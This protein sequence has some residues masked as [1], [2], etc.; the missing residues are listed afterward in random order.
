MAL[1]RKE[2]RVESGRGR[3]SIHDSGTMLGRD[4]LAVA[5]GAVA[6][7]L[8]QAK[9]AHL[10]F[11][12]V[13]AAVELI[14]G[15]EHGSIAEVGRQCRIVPKAESSELARQVDL[16]MQETGQGPCLDAIWENQTVRVDD[17]AAE[18]RWPKFSRRAA[19]ADVRSMLSF[20]LYVAGGNLGALNVYSSRP[21]AFSDESE[22]VGLLV[23]THA[24]VA[25]AGVQRRDQLEDAVDTRDL[26]GRAIGIVMERYTI[27]GDRAFATLT[28]LSQQSN[29]KLRDIAAEIVRD[30]EAAGDQLRG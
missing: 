27:T 2:C 16:L 25:L 18:L 23:A 21:G 24:A 3:P 14:P 6:R 5:L 12:V 13:D 29:R 9:S 15:A 26:I 7:E 10:L 28:R 20:Q 8:Q 11:G 30:T 4:R 22:H 1:P 17:T 19:E